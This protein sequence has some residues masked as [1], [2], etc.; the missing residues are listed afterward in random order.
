MHQ[1]LFFIFIGIVGLIALSIFIW[2]ILYVYRYQKKIDNWRLS[3]KKR[4]WVNV[5]SLNGDFEFWNYNNDGTVVIRVHNSDHYWFK[6]VPITEIWPLDHRN[7]EW[8]LV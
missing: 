5:D 6:T 4:Q 7:I 2:M 8:E 3:L 1:L